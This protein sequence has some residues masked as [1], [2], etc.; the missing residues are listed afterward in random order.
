M[1]DLFSCRL[2]V[3]WRTRLTFI[4]GGEKF[5]RLH[6]TWGCG[7]AAGFPLSLRNLGKWQVGGAVLYLHWLAGKDPEVPAKWFNRQEGPFLMECNCVCHSWLDEMHEVWLKLVL[8]AKCFQVKKLAV[9]DK[10]ALLQKFSSQAQACHV[11]LYRERLRLC[12]S[13]HL[14]FSFRRVGVL[15]CAPA[16]WIDDNS[17]CW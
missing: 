16:L 4:W 1:L 15:T 6:L 3:V 7:R 2:L 10:T 14:S 5:S 17:H 12:L 8:F 11:C 9:A 13:S